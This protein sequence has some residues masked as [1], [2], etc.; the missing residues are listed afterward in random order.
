MKIN[1]RKKMKRKIRPGIEIENPIAFSSIAGQN[2]DISEQKTIIKTNL[3]ILWFLF[4]LFLI[5]MIIR[6]FYLQVIKG[7]YYQKIAENNRIRNIEV[8]APRGLIVDING[9]VLASNIPSFD[10]VFVPSEIPKNSAEKEEIFLSLGEE[11]GIFRDEIADLIEKADR[12]ST[13]KHLIK[14]GV[15]YDKALVL[16]EKLQK[17]PGIYLEKTAQRKYKNGEIFSAILGYTGKINKKE[18]ELNV[19]Y[20][21]TDYIGKNGLEYSYE[22]WLKGQSGRLKMEVNS[23]GSIK[24]E[25]GIIPPISGDKLILNID[26]KIQEKAYQTLKNLLEVNK[27]ATG[28]SVVAL[29]PRDGSVRALVSLPSYDNNL[30]AGGIVESQYQEI[31]NDN[32]KPM[33]NRAIGGEYPPG[34]VFKPLLAAMALEEGAIKPETF[35]DCPGAISIGEWTFRDWK[36]HGKTDLNKAIAE[37]CNVYFYALGGGW[38]NIQ[39]LGV[40]KMSKYSEYFGLG[41]TLGIDIPGE[42]SGRIPDAEWKFKEIGDRWYIGDSYHMSI[43]QGFMTTTPL[44]MA[45]ATAVVANKGILYKPRIVN[46]IIKTDGQEEINQTEIVRNNFISGVN[47]EKIKQAMRETVLSGSGRTLNDM[48]T[49]TA[50]KTGTAQF[51]NKTRTHSWYVSFAPYQNPEIVTAVIIESGGEGHDWAVPVTEQILREYFNEEP[52]NIDWETVNSIVKNR[53]RMLEGNF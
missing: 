22:K 6:V 29:D 26:A 47:F 20:S 48:K 3:R 41:K 19:E 40:N 28:A 15:D 45:S 21:L 51:G 2:E 10:L 4:S 31:I 52:E 34:S 33:M 8:K 38:N 16:I 42:T 17:L 25:L 18:L 37:S 14:S 23:D 36:T 44:Q 13:K 32:K 9:E 49:E 50:G 46:K 39:G 43:G 35:L 53:G 1:F 5:I 30:F 24:E 7:S 11:L 12:K 27:E